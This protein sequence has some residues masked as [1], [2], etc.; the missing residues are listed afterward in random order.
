MKSEYQFRPCYGG[1][2]Y[3]DGNCANCKQVSYSDR[4]EETECQN[5]TFLISTNTNT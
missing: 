2:A 4:T 1:W 5:R 3:C